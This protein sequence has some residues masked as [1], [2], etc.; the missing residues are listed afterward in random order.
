MFISVR[1]PNKNKH[2][3]PSALGRVLRSRPCYWRYMRVTTFFILFI[4]FTVSANASEVDIT[5][6]GISNTD[7]PSYILNAYAYEELREKNEISVS[8]ALIWE[9]S[10]SSYCGSN[11]YF[12][13]LNI[14]LEHELKKINDTSDSLGP[15]LR[16]GFKDKC[17]YR[18]IISLENSPFKFLSKFKRRI[19]TA[20]VNGELVTWFVHENKKGI[21]FIPQHPKETILECVENGI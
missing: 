3:A 14:A 19:Y 20:L 8:E 11:E 13:K 5:T 9:Y 21:K 1:Q 18:A 12:E 4:S 15:V 2:K 6:C 7:I 10:S 17:Q 16:N